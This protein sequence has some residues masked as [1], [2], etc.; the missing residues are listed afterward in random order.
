MSMEELH[1]TKLAR[2]QAKKENRIKTIITS[3]LPTKQNLQGCDRTEN[4]KQETLK[5]DS[6]DLKEARHY[7]PKAGFYNLMTPIKVPL[8]F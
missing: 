2:W 8:H 4:P 6:S 1:I 3:V 7:K 5:R